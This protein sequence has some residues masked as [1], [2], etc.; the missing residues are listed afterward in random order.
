[1]Q[2]SLTPIEQWRLQYFGTTANSGNS[3]DSFDANKDGESNLLEFA[4]SQNPNAPTKAVTSVVKNG[5]ALEFTYPRSNAAMLDGVTFTVQWSDTLATNSWSSA[6]VTEQI[7][8][9]NGT[10]QSVKASVAAASG[11][12]RFLRLKISK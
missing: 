3:A 12:R 8:S 6:G 2:T 9:D 4:T 5:S 11:G 1:M 7:L 10:V